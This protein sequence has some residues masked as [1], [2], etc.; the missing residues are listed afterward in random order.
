MYPAW[1]F[2]QGG[3]AIWPLYPTG[4]GRWD[5]MSEELIQE[6]N[7]MTWEDK[8]QTA[9]FRGTRT[10]DERDFLIRLN[11]N[12]PEL[13]N[14]TYIKHQSKHINDK[15]IELFGIQP[16]EPVSLVDHC[17][18]MYLINMKGV[19]AS[20]RYKY[21]FLCNS[22]VFQINGNEEWKEM[23]YD[24]MIP[25]IHYIP[26]HHSSKIEE[27]LTIEYFNSNQDQAKQISQNGYDFIKNHLRMDDIY[28]YWKELL[29]QYSK[30][31][32]YIPT[33]DMTFIEK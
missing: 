1:T 5:I 23:F 26:I 21:L 12:H 29:L 14:A 20:F 7:S 4:L 17:H 18:Y 16:G 8:F 9:Y 27:E 10:S 31:V 3:P 25:W 24:A 15:T 11:T 30:L 33:R 32:D 6:S 28:L 2:W 13:V 19:A 22:L